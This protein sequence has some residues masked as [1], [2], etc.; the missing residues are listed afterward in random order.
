M[1]STH[2]KTPAMVI[3]LGTTPALAGLEL[4]RQLLTLGDEDRHCVSFVH[5]DTDDMPSKVSE[6]YRQHEGKFAKFT[7]RVAV[8]VGINF[9]DD[10]AQGSYPDVPADQVPLIRW[11][12]YVRNKTPQYFDTGAGG[13]RNNGHVALCFHRERIL[14]RLEEALNS[15]ERLSAVEG[16]R[17]VSKLQVYVVSFLGGGTGSGMLADVAVMARRMIERRQYGQRLIAYCILPGDHIAGATQNEKDWRGSNATATLLE[18]M[19][20]GLAAGN[21]DGYYSKFLLDAQYRIRFGPIFNEVLLI[22]RTHMATVQDTA[23]IVGNDLF[24]RITDASGLGEKETSVG[25]DRKE[26]AD[27]DDMLLPTYFGT[28]CPFEVRFPA[29]E[30]AQAFAEYSA[31]YLLDRLLP[32]PPRLRDVSGKYSDWRTKWSG[33]AAQESVPRFG[34]DRFRKATRARLDA[35]WDRLGQYQREISQRL[36]EDI[37]NVRTRE[38][39]AITTLRSADELNAI[40]PPVEGNDLSNPITRRTLHLLLLKSEYDYMLAVLKEQT[41]ASGDMGR[42]VDLE[43]K[44]VEGIPYVPGEMEIPYF[45]SVWDQRFAAAVWTKYNG[46]VQRYYRRE[47]HAALTKLIT[48]LR[49]TVE[50]LLTE[51]RNAREGMK[52]EKHKRDMRNQSLERPVWQGKLESEHPHFTHLYGL[53]SLPQ[54][55]IEGSYT[56]KAAVKGLYLWITAGKPTSFRYV[57]ATFEKQRDAALESLQV[58]LRERWRASLGMD[59]AVDA[60]VK[61]GALT[62]EE[63]QAVRASSLATTVVES[64]RAAYEEDLRECNLFELLQVG[65]AASENRPHELARARVPAVLGRHLANIKELIRDLVVNEPELWRNGAKTIKV[66]LFLGINRDGERDDERLLLQALRT[67]GPLAP[68]AEVPGYDRVESDPHRMQIGYSKHG[69]SIRTLPEFY[70]RYDDTSMQHFLDNQR[71][72]FGDGNPAAGGSYGGNKMPVHSSGEMERLVWT[73]GVLGHPWRLVERV[74]RE[75]RPGDGGPGGGGVSRQPYGPPSGPRPG[76][77]GGHSGP[78]RD[79]SYPGTGHHYPDA[80]DPGAPP[81]DPFADNPRDREM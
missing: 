49:D 72:W 13:I 68:D 66:A 36:R 16:E 53:N 34:I 32:E 59:D 28:S 64:L 19:A 62:A 14:G 77:G 24:Q 60:D 65:I 81:Y 74:I 76:P 41:P 7:A 51:E 54:E 80:S 18:L 63:V 79:P 12:T 46:I 30:T 75:D 5:I 52:L 55:S 56:A 67:V 43:R 10:P 42:P 22:G 70:R 20:H 3:M 17:T 44:L 57:S 26:L 48:D 1:R 50:A 37:T 15:L 29:N 6:F 38:E 8:P 27:A 21:Q 2:V 23:A 61:S 47:R 71:R 35:N 69:I 40:M 4:C 25:P 73:P 39:K 33:A 78:Y 9:A 45:S 31:S 11:H 58:R